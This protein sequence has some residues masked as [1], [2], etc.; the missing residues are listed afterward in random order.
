MLDLVTKGYLKFDKLRYF[1]LDEC[2]KMLEH[3]DMRGDVQAIFK[4]TPHDKQVMM[5]SATLSKSIRA[6]CRKFMQKQLEIFIDDEA[7]L[8]LDGL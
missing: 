5:F 1:V 6:V 2:D 7:K 4:H 8:K 3:L